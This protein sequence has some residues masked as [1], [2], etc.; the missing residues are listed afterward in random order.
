MARRLE[1]YQ[2]IEPTTPIAQPIS[3]WADSEVIGEPGRYKTSV[4]VEVSRRCV[5]SDDPERA[6]ILCSDTPTSG[7][8]IKPTVKYFTALGTGVRLEVGD[9]TI[10]RLSEALRRVEPSDLSA[11]P[12]FGVFTGGGSL[13][14]VRGCRSLSG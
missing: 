7:F 11:T 8:P 3:M 6:G 9:A 10:V 12:A 4:E 13:W 1:R 14:D 5:S 2:T